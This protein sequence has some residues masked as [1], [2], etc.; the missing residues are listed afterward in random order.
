MGAPELVEAL[1]RAVA[2]GRVSAGALEFVSSTV[3]VPDED[4]GVDVDGLRHTYVRRQRRYLPDSF[5]HKEIQRLLNSIQSEPA[6]RVDLVP[7]VDG[8]TTTTMFIVSR[9]TG[10]ILYWSPMWKLAAARM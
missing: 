7:L 4:H 1:M 10:E 9:G 2:A 6:P 3:T 5:E 8:G